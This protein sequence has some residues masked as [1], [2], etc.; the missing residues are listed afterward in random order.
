MVSQLS[1]C[2]PA[3]IQS[4]YHT[5]TRKM[6]SRYRI[7]YVISVLPSLQWLHIFQQVKTKIISV[8]HSV[9]CNWPEVTLLTS[10]PVTH[11]CTHSASSQL[12]PCCSLNPVDKL[13]QQVLQPQFPLLGKLLLKMCMLVSFP[14]L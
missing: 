7:N 10:F 14:S 3:V 4:I 9:L 6:L 1:H 5:A 13:Q 8:I 2:S 11:L 12:P